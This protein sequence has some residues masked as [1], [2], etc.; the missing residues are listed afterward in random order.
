VVDP[1]DRKRGQEMLEIVLQAHALLLT[2]PINP[3]ERELA[4]PLMKLPAWTLDVT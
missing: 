1:R 2:P 3:L 4:R